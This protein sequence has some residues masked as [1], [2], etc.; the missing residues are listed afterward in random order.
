M[1]RGGIEGKLP[2]GGKTLH[3]LQGGEYGKPPIYAPKIPYRLPPRTPCDAPLEQVQ[4]K[5]SHQ[6]SF[7][8]GIIFQCSAQY[9]SSQTSP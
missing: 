2:I 8:I 9:N 4:T 7:I 1:F 5:P 3:P 6:S